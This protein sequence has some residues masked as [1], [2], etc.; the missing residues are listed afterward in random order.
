[1]LTNV[2]LQFLDCIPDSDESQN[3]GCYLDNYLGHVLVNDLN[4]VLDSDLDHISNT[5]L[6]RLLDFK[7]KNTCPLRECVC[8]CVLVAGFLHF[9]HTILHTNI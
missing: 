3:L 1:M 7:R 6:D 5:N 2:V 9:L 8:V 4:C